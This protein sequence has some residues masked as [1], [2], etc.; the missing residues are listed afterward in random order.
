LQIV[1]K[2]RRRWLTAIEPVEELGRDCLV[3]LPDDLGLRHLA[4]LPRPRR[5]PLLDAHDV[6]TI[7]HHCA[8]FALQAVKLAIPRVGLA[9][10]QIIPFVASEAPVRHAQHKERARL[11]VEGIA[12]SPGRG[13]A[14]DMPRVPVPAGDGLAIRATEVSQLVEVMNA[15]LD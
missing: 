2:R 4:G 8:A 14:A 11:A 13:L 5:T 12:A 6:V 1:G 3:A 10:L 15:A 7:E 9:A